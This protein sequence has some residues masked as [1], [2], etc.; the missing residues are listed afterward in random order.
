MSEQQTLL[1]SANK[2]QSTAQVPPVMNSKSLT[3]L[4]AVGS[5]VKGVLGLQQGPTSPGEKVGKTSH[6][7]AINYLI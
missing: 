7:N 1:L 6:S 5:G 2:G 4:R 3:M